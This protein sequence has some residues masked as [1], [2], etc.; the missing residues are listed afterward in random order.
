VL[1]RRVPGGKFKDATIRLVAQVT[2]RRR[3][4]FVIEVFWWQDA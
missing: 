2:E 1:W 4:Q 3:K